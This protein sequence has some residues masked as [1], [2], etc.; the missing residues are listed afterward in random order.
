MIDEVVDVPKTVE[1]RAAWAHKVAEIAAR[2]SEA[3]PFPSNEND[4]WFQINILAHKVLWE[5]PEAA[6]V[7]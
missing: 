2:C 3:A 7:T 4:F 5:H 1:E 6:E